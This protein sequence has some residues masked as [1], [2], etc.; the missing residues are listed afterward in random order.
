MSKYPKITLKDLV[1]FEPKESVKEII[2]KRYNRFIVVS[3]AGKRVLNNGHSIYYNCKC[4]CGNEVIVSAGHLKGGKT[5]SCGCLRVDHPNRFVH[6][7]APLKGKREKIYLSWKGMHARTKDYSGKVD[8][9]KYIEKG[10]RVCEGW[11]GKD[12][13]INFKNQMSP[14]T[15]KSLDRIDNNLHYSCGLCEECKRE[16]W[17]LNC[18]WA[19]DDTQ[20]NNRGDFNNW[21]KID[22]VLMTYTQA[23]RYLG[24]PE[25]TLQRRIKRFGWS[26]EKAIKTPVKKIK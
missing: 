24:F 1:I 25:K 4:D 5:K 11:S 2:G 12:G 10:I 13:F 20:S 19:D 15:N 22:G 18:R 26:E 9:R 23:S 17:K 7:Y 6:G 21:I 14:P 16:N 8:T 3:V